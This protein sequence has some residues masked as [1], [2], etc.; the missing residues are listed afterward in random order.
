MAT[1][2]LCLA[3]L[4]AGRVV[5]PLQLCSGAVASCWL[6]LAQ[7]SSVPSVLAFRRS[8]DI[9]DEVLVHLG[10]VLEFQHLQ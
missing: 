5:G 9:L 8:A 10:L 1:T 2:A 7:C 3:S 6:K 4:V